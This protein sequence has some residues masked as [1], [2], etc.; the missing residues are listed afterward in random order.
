MHRGKAQAEPPND[1]I[2]A[3][4]DD[5]TDGIADK[6]AVITARCGGTRAGYPIHSSPVLL[7]RTPCPINHYDISAETA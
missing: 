3:I 7:P 5:T 6:F 4:N 1:S 2:S